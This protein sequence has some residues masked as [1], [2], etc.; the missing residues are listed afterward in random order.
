M[1]EKIL[2]N[3][4]LAD[5]I[6]EADTRAR[7]MRG[8]VPPYEGDARSM[9]EKQLRALLEEQRRRAVERPDQVSY[10]F[11]T[12]GVGMGLEAIFS[13]EAVDHDSKVYGKGRRDGRYNL[14]NEIAEAMAIS[15]GSG[16]M[17]RRNT[18]ETIRKTLDE[19]SAIVGEALSPLT[20]EDEG[21]PFEED[22]KGQKNE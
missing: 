8:C 10:E 15:N 18:E 13:E 17:N 21:L 14:A 2:T 9:H 6:R 4:E 7:T 20:E 19:V 1:S 12:Q 3:K 16:E 11:S 5:A 22:Q